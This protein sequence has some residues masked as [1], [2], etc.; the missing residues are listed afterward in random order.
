[1]HNE[2]ACH[3]Y[4][5]TSFELGTRVLS[6][7]WLLTEPSCVTGTVVS[8]PAIVPPLLYTRTLHGS[9]AFLLT[10]HSQLMRV[11]AGR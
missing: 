5:S 6:W 8:T 4:T 11:K 9:R 7:L 10:S 2:L 1:M 3:T